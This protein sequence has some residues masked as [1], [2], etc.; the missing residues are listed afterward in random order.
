MIPVIFPHILSQQASRG[1]TS[2]DGMSNITKFSHISPEIYLP[3]RGWPREARFS[4]TY[5]K[6]EAPELYNHRG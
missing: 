5:P 2:L 6:Y 3:L 1:S 4:I